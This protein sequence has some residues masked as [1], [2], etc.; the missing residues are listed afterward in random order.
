MVVSNEAHAL[1]AAALHRVQILQKHGNDRLY[2]QD[3]GRLFHD[4]VVVSEAQVHKL[5]PCDGRVGAG[6]CHDSCLLQQEVVGAHAVIAQELKGAEVPKLLEDLGHVTETA[7]GN[8]QVGVVILA[9]EHLRRVGVR[10]ECLEGKEFGHAGLRAPSG[11]R[12]GHV[13]LELLDAGLDVVEVEELGGLASVAHVRV[14]AEGGGQALD[15]V[16]ECLA[17]AQRVVDPA[18]LA[19]VLATSELCKGLHPSAEA[20]EVALLD[21]AFHDLL[22]EVVEGRV[23]VGHNQR[24]LVREV[25][26]EVCDDL[27]RNIGL[28]C[29]WRPHDHGESLAHAAADGLGLHRSEPHSILLGLVHRVRPR[30]RGHVAVHD[31]ALPIPPLAAPRLGHALEA[32]PVRRRWGGRGLAVHG[33][34]ELSSLGKGLPD[35]GRVEECVP[36]IRGWLRRGVLCELLLSL[37]LP[38]VSCRRVP[39]AQEDVVEPRG[40][41][42]AHGSRAHEVPD[43]LEDAPEVVLLRLAAHENVKAP[44]GVVAALHVRVVLCRVQP[45]PQDPVVARAPTL[46]GVRFHGLIQEDPVFVDELVNFAPPHGPNAVALH[47]VQVLL[48]RRPDHVPL[49]A[50]ALAA[51]APHAAGG[52]T[53]G[54]RRNPRRSRGARWVVGRREGHEEHHVVLP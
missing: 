41:G 23:R 35:V 7:T 49:A 29:T 9:L 37:E 13:C 45:H 39:V 43:G 12:S 54:R 51:P 8:L 16:Q 32:E 44:V 1:E 53:R 40:H 19:V 31:H 6:H 42:L 30:V 18:E 2:F 33:E 36:E 34:D 10:E 4:E 46:A 3:L 48:V 14:D 27:H 22:E 47:K 50:A 24:L 52:W 38:V 26:V 21:V 17:S 20:Q 28:A 11:A 5:P 15:L 25:V